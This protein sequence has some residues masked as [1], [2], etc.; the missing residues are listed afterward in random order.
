MQTKHRFGLIHIWTKGEVGAPWNRFK[1]LVKLVTDRSKA[2]LLLWTI[3]LISVLFCRAFVRVCLLMSCGHLLGQGWPL[4]SHLLCLIVKLVSWVTC[5]AW[6]YQFLM[7]ALVL[8]FIREY[9]L[10]AK[11]NFTL[12]TTEYIFTVFDLTKLNIAMSCWYP[13]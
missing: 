6:L 13:P 9:I 4:G 8:T 3:Y 12:W 7:F 5:C 10:K 11:S 2:V 1:P